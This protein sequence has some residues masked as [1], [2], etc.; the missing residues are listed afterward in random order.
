M[1]FGEIMDENKNYPSN[2]W[3]VCQFYKIFSNT[4]VA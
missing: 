4:I 2:P 1:C 3:V